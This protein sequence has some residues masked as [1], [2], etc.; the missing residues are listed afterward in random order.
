MGLKARLEDS[1]ALI[2]TTIARVKAHLFRGN[3][4]E[5]IVRRFDINLRTPGLLCIVQT[6]LDKNIGKKG[7]INLYDQSGIHNTSIFL[8]QLSRECVEIFLIVLVI[9][10]RPDTRRS[11]CG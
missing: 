6:G 7:I 11:S 1:R 3:V 9:F 5:C 8:I 2:D 4:V 10:I